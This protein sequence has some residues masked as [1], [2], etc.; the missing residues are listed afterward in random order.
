MRR[1]RAEGTALLVVEQQVGHALSLCERVAVLDHGS[2]SWT[3]PS[4]EAAERVSAQL[5]VATAT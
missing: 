5:S 3:G 2:V 1:L 4:A